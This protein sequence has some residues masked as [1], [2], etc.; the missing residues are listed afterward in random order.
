MAELDK[1][2]AA[3]S[4]DEF[5]SDGE[6]EAEYDAEDDG[7]DSDGDYFA[8]LQSEEQSRRETEQLLHEAQMLLRKQHDQEPT[9]EHLQYASGGI[10][11]AIALLSSTSAESGGVFEDQYGGDDFSD[12]ADADADADADI[13]AAENDDDGFNQ[14][15]SDQE[16]HND[17]G[18]NNTESRE[19]ESEN[20]GAYTPRFYVE[21]YEL[22]PR[23]APVFKQKPNTR[24]ST[25]AMGDGRRKLLPVKS[26]P[27]LRINLPSMDRTKRN[28]LFLNM[29]RHGDDVS[30]YEPFIPKL[31]VSP[32]A[33][34]QPS[35]G[36]PV[37]P[38]SAAQQSYA[39]SQADAIAAYGGTRSSRNGRRLVTPQD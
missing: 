30:K 9:R 11:E 31:L 15:A 29:F 20:V 32:S 18:G 16:G 8:E 37:R 36:R 24:S 5:A 21:E 12:D 23:K 7:D 34:Q 13:L 28:W 10:G 38:Y 4:D 17:G 26:P 1:E 22:P 19:A 39:S 14:Y 35:A 6:Y 27:N 33:P 3:Y 25:S 2:Q